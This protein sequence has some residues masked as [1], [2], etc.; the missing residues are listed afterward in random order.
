MN[1]Q[2]LVTII[3][4]NYPHEAAIARG[5]LE[6]E[7]MEVFT[8]DE[9]TVQVHNFYSNAV[10][11]VKLQVWENDME[12]AVEILKESSFANQL[13]DV[14]MKQE[15]EPETDAESDPDIK[16]PKQKILP[17]VIIFLLVLLLI[18]FMFL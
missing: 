2:E 8:K 9:L 14:E 13:I 11:G 3:R 12:R 17:I 16:K 7:G 4:F 15:A 6:N 1:T 18:C 5:L 10:G